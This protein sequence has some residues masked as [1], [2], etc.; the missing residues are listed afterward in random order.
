MN[1]K[2]EKF[3]SAFDNEN[4]TEVTVEVTVPDCPETELIINSKANFAG[5]RK[6]YEKAYNDN[7]E[8]NSFNDIKIIGY[9]F[10]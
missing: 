3:L 2:K 10:N 7:L 9:K 6:Y 4:Y 8:L 5:K 1:N